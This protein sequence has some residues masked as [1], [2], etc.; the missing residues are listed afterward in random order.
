MNGWRWVTG[1][2]IL[3]LFLLS[4]APARAERTSGARV[5]T[6]LNNGARGDITV[7]YTTDGRSTFMVNGY[8]APYYFATPITDDP[9]NPGARPVFN[10]YSFYGATKH[11]GSTEGT[12]PREYGPTPH[13]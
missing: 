5:P 12:A 10:V 4:A 8:V 3:S 9:R 2:A 7:P 1:L 13:H 6:F 11:Y